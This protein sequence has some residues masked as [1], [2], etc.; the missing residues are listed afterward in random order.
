[1]IWKNHPEKG[2][3]PDIHGAHSFYEIWQYAYPNYLP[4][5]RFAQIFGDGGK[6]ECKSVI[7]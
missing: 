7:I 6:G 2:W 3:L 4:K 5:R 1:L